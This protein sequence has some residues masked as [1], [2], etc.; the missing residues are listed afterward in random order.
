MRR[1]SRAGSGSRGARGRA[2]P[3]ARRGGAVARAAQPSRSACSSSPPRRRSSSASRRATSRSSASS[4]SWSTSRRRRPSPPRWPRASSTWGPPASPPRSTTSCWAARSS[5]SWPTRAAS[6]RATRWWR[7][8]VQKE[9]WDGGG[10]RSI[11]DLKG[12]R[13]GVTQIGSTFHYHIGNILE[14]DGLTPGRR[15]DRAAPGHARHHG[16]AQGQAG[17]RDP[18]AAALPGR[19]RG[20]GLRQD[21]GVGRRPLSR[22]RSPPSSTPASSRPIAPARWPS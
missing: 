13:I 17:G 7:I 8:V 5:G 2:L 16:G 4:P 19:R 1:L 21:H 22:G 6:G 14:K 10:L 18:G 3:L 9:L 11:K 20:A 12:K 15:E